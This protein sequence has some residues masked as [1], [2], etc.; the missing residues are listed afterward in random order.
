MRCLPR[1]DCV[2][3]NEAE[4]CRGMMSRNNFIG[5]TNIALGQ[6]TQISREVDQLANQ[7]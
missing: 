3:L 4:P 6:A 7:A 2:S 5:Q 1:A